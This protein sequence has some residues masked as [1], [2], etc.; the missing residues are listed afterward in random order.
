MNI[1]K[2]NKMLYDIPE[3]L[4]LV[5]KRTSVKQH[6]DEENFENV[7]GGEVL[8]CTWN[9]GEYL[10]GVKN[11]Y[12]L[13]TIR[14]INSSNQT[15]N[16]SFGTAGCISMFEDI[17]VRSRS[18]VE[19][20]RINEPKF[21]NKI[22]YY[23]DTKTERKN[24]VG[25]IMGFEKEYP[26]V[27]PET[28]SYVSFAIP[29][30]FLLP[31]FNS[32]DG[33]EYM[34]SQMCEGLT[35]EFRLADPN[36]TFTILTNP[37]DTTE[38]TKIEFVLDCVTLNDRSLKELNNKCHSRGLE[39]TCVDVYKQDILNTI[40]GDDVTNQ[41]NY[42]VSQ[43]IRADTFYLSS[44]RFNSQF[45]DK[46][47]FLPV[48]SGF[49]YRSGS[50]YYP[51]YKIS[52]LIST[53]NQI[54][55][56]LKAIDSYKDSTTTY[57]DFISST[58]RRTMFSTSLNMNDD[59]PLSGIIVNNSKTLEYLGS[60]S[61]TYSTQSMDIMTLLQYVKVIKIQDMNVSVAV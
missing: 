45:F 42:S 38:L 40:A 18:G 11:S 6:F 33:T 41:I 9:T 51:Q 59:L 19:L 21:W 32:I 52:G 49:Q 23:F 1:Y 28:P 8:R 10:V 61:S 31:I 44:D 15:G 53:L 24:E 35:F 48:P 22:K 37:F 57:D 46:S 56:F 12:L 7:R 3:S 60:G 27:F 54:E 14:N 17:I 34:P 20:T 55:A 39:W 26:I 43:G 5:K 50:D 36:K 25:D 4:T 16:Y 2:E 47:G 13:F 30:E 58:K 29:L